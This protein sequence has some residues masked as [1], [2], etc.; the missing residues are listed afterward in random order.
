[1]GECE[2]AA[3]GLCSLRH[4]A[5]PADAPPA[6]LGGAVT[7]TVLRVESPTSYWVRLALPPEERRF[8]QSERLVLALARH[9]STPAAR[10]PI[11]K[12][13]RGALVAI[14]GRE[15]VVRRARV[16]GL[17]Y[18]PAGGG[19]RRLERLEVFTVDEGSVEVVGPEEVYVL[20]TALSAEA[21][22]AAATRLVVVGV[23]PA[24]LDRDWGAAAHMMV[25]AGLLAR[26]GADAVVRARLA[27]FSKPV[28]N[29]ESI[30][31][32]LT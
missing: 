15:G 28:F 24:H 18:G 21:F 30:R 22:P 17:V 6:A 26:N 25:A 14:L 16:T 1:M 29:L 2:G 13:E 3:G 7:C 31:E 8:G 19:G 12:V 20:P 4:R 9:Y 23:R 27:P 5:M 11:T 32:A 10:V